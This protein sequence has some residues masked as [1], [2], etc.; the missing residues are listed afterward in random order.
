MKDTIISLSVL[1]VLVIGLVV[2]LVGCGI[3]GPSTQE[4]G[5]FVEIREESGIIMGTDYRIVYDR[6]TKVMYY[7]SD[8]MYN[9][10]SLCPLYNADGSVMIYDGNDVESEEEDGL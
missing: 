10:C 4:G 3:A 8:S 9:H 2:Q 5:R 7:M 1:V 6:T